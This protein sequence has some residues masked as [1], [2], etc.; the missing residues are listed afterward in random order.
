[1]G[2]VSLT[3]NASGAA[4]AAKRGDIVLIVDVIDMSTT[5]E[6]VLDAGAFRVFGASPAGCKAPVVLN[7]EQIGKVAGTLAVQGKNKLVIVS[8]PRAG[9]D[10]ERRLRSAPVIRGAELAGAEI[11]A[12]YP[13]CGA[14]IARLADFRDRVV[15]AVT[16][17]GG[18]AF[19][20]AF[21]A[22]APLVITGTIA[23]TMQKRGVE[24]AR[25]AAKRAVNAAIDANTGITVVASSANSLEEILAAEFIMKLIIEEGFTTL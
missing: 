10:E 14:E 8:E 12:I 1:M 5:L 13:N 15:V 22:R 6:A 19:D 16:D 25:A 3:V 21:T 2:M 23:R 20:A 18:V 7:P 24:P 9:S 17:T 4:E 11:E